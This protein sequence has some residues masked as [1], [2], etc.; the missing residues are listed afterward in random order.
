MLVDHG[1]EGR[2]E[3]DLVDTRALDVSAHA[4]ELEAGRTAGALGHVPVGALEEDH[5][6]VGKRLDVVDDC[7]FPEEAV[8]H[9]KGRLQ[10][11]LRPA[12]LEHLE[13]RALLAADVAARAREDLEVERVRGAEDLRAKDAAGVR[14]RD[15]IAEDAC[16][17]PVLVAD[18]YD[19]APRASDDPGER[20][21]LD[22]EVWHGG[23]DAAVLDGA[24]LALVGVA[25]DVLLV[26]GRVADG[27]PL[28]GGREAGAAHAAELRGL[29]GRERARHVAGLDEFAERGVARLAGPVGVGAKH[30]GRHRCGRRRQRRAELERGED[31]VAAPVCQAPVRLVVHR[32][33]RRAVAAPEARDG[34]DGHRP[35]RARLARRLDLAQERVA[36]A[37]TAA[38][39]GADADI[40]RRRRL[41]TEVR[42]EGGYAVEMVDGYAQ[43]GGE[44]AKRGLCQ[45]AAAAALGL[46][47][48]LDRARTCCWLHRR[49]LAERS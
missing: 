38:H 47:E 24:R 33:R 16:L 43:L 29:E 13:E 2:P 6:Y 27:L 18:V 8:R 21:A 42:E 44:G 39:V 22:E 41:E 25:D 28:D 35:S 1:A 19:A 3:G 11:R 32:E 34:P 12:T 10:A 30:G 31:G 48:G 49:W 23:E 17:G 37:E 20:H 5:G 45:V 46:L 14:R 26:A 7:R 9:G 40:E 4:D 36:A 15:G